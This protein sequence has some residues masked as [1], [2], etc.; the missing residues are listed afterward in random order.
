MAVFYGKNQS[1]RYSLGKQLGG[2]GEGAVHEIVGKKD[3]VAKV[4][5]DSRFTPTY[6][7]PDPRRELKEKIETMLEQ[8]INPYINGVLTVAWPQDIL[9]DQQGRFVGYTMPRVNSKYHLYSASRERERVQ[10][11]PSY[12]WK[13]AI[14]IAY[15]LALVVGVL[16]N[17]NVVLGDMNPNNIMLDEKGH[18]TVIDIDSCN[19]SNIRTGKTYKC[20]VGISECLA[21]ELQ[22]KNLAKETSMFTKQSDS[23]SLA[24]HIFTLLMNNC[25]PFGCADFKKVRSSVSNDPLAKP[26][27]EGDCPY[28]SGAT[29]PTSPD[30]PDMKMIPDDVRQLF[31]R[32]FQYTLSTAVKPATI[33]NRPTA[34]EWQIAM[35][36]LLNSKMTECTMA[37]PK[38]HLYPESYHN[39]CPWCELERRRFV[40][41]A[42][43]S[44]P[45]AIPYRNPTQRGNSFVPNAK[46]KYVLGSVR[47]AWPLWLICIMT[48]IIGGL[49]LAPL[50]LKIGANIEFISD[51]TI[52][53]AYVL[54]ST[55]GAI[56]GGTIALL[57]QQSY[58]HA[59]TAWPWL[60]LSLLAPVG[61]VPV[62]GALV[63]VVYLITAVL[64]LLFAFAVICICLELFVR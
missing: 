28:V 53:E 41:A 64:C 21:P 27:I 24:I 22:G 44:A 10:L 63:L 42:Q 11:Y 31:D 54:L 36:H 30:A 14:L 62:A 34:E 17:S 33:A 48:G 12:S 32:T 15:N 8:P 1:I 57:S 51:M 46:R 58:T 60:C 56:T 26:I 7:S 5:H 6:E 61:A 35:Y 2:G 55:S 43:N 47:G 52:N 29:G 38:R 13:T 4:Y 19:I 20:R 49:L 45:G 59:G 23:F 40:P 50:V 39:T 37:L 25:H 18:V 9:T 3:L 16:H